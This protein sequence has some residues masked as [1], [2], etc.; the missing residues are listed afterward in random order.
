M[1]DPGL[2]TILAAIISGSLGVGGTLLAQNSRKK[3]LTS[4]NVKDLV[5]LISGATGVGKTEISHEIGKE[6]PIYRN[7]GTDLIREILRQSET[8]P[9]DT[10]VIKES[11]FLV[12]HA[13]QRSV[14]D[15]VRLQ[16]K[17]VWP[18]LKAVIDRTRER[19]ISAIFEGV[20][21]L[22]SQVFG[23]D[24]Y[25]PNPRLR[26]LFVCLFIKDEVTHLSRV[27]NRGFGGMPRHA[28]ERKYLDNMPLIREANDVFRQ[29]AEQTARSQPDAKILVIDNASKI[30]KTTKQVLN[31]VREFA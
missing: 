6:F 25:T 2:A 7:I 21:I 29:D 12:G 27:E 18:A 23:H 9:V 8:T 31:A 26:L 17:A 14:E 3:K 11:S 28:G 22:A 15:G 13:I 24:G 4:A 30:E 19:R 16:S 1:V 5:L 20:N 10:T